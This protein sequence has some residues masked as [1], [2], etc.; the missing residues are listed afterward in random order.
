LPS[1]I[2]VGV[3]VHDRLLYYTYVCR[4]ARIEFDNRVLTESHHWLYRVE[5]LPTSS[6]SGISNIMAM[7]TWSWHIT[8]L[9]S[10]VIPTMNVIPAVTYG[11]LIAMIE[12]DDESTCMHYHTHLT[13]LLYPII[14]CDVCLRPNSSGAPA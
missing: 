12:L 4:V 11:S 1:Y 9:T 3:V 10:A 8:L 6:S 13:P 7:Q 2:S 5:Y 14:V